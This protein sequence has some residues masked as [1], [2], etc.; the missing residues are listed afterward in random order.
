MMTRQRI[1]RG[2]LSPLT[3]IE[4]VQY[5][6]YRMLFLMWSTLVIAFAAAYFMVHTF[7]QGHGLEP[8]QTENSLLVLGNSLYFSIITATTVGYGDLLPQGLAKVFAAIQ[9]ISSFFLMTI[10]VSKL[11]S[12][13]QELAIQQVHKLSFEQIFHNVREGLYVIRKDFDRFIHTAHKHEH[14]SPHEWE[15]LTVA[16]R[17]GLSL[18]EDIP[19]FYDSDHQLYTIDM[20][21]EQLLLESVHRTLKRIS[22]MLDTFGEIGIDWKIQSESTHEM[23]LFVEMI[24]SLLPI[25]RSRSPY[26]HDSDFTGIAEE[27]HRL[28]E[29]L[30]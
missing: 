15:N 7:T 17:E 3:L 26:N 10:F 23:E 6:P 5:L 13:R 18:L 27:N 2:I 16:Y 12:Y 1:R 28:E 19:G 21:R 30:R 8:L 29:K 24:A 25:W 22:H 9:A 4:R 11:V 14:I 20:R